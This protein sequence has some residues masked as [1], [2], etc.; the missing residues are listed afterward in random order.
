MRDPKHLLLNKI[1]Q[2]AKVDVT[3]EQGRIIVTPITETKYSL[4]ELLSKV[5][6]RNLH[7]EIGTGNP[8]GKE[9]G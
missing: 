7:K 3:L 4:D 1:T 5:N 8:I 6:K 9:I 2:G